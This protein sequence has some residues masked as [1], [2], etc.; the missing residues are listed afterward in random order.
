MTEKEEETNDTTGQDNEDSRSNTEEEEVEQVETNHQKGDEQEKEGESSSNAE[1]NKGILQDAFEKSTFAAKWLFILSFGFGLI[2][3]LWINYTGDRARDRLLDEMKNRK[4]P[5]RS[6]ELRKNLKPEEHGENGARYYRAAFKASEKLCGPTDQLPL[7]GVEGPQLPDLGERLPERWRKP[8]RR[9]RTEHKP[10]YDLLK[11]ARTYDF[12]AYSINRSMDVDPSNEYFELTNAH[13][14]AI[15]LSLLSLYQEL[16]G[17]TGG[18]VNSILHILHITDSFRYNPRR[19]LS[20]IRLTL[21]SIAISRFQELLSRT[22]IPETE[23]NELSRALSR[24]F[25]HLKITTTLKSRLALNANYLK[26]I[27][28][29][30]AYKLHEKEDFYARNGW[31]PNGPVSDV[32]NWI[33]KEDE[34]T[35]R[36]GKTMGRISLFLYRLHATLAPGYYESRLA[37]RM[38]VQ[39][40]ILKSLGKRRSRDLKYLRSLEGTEETIAGRVRETVARLAESWT[41][42]WTKVLVTRLAI[43][44]EQF[45]MERGRWP[46]RRSEIPQRW[47]AD[48]YGGGP[49]KFRTVQNGVVIYSVGPNGNDDGGIQKQIQVPGGDISF[50]LFDPAKRGEAPQLTPSSSGN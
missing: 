9:F 44:V 16:E 10:L 40:K 29:Y 17:N 48:P 3:I 33:Y 21:I 31:I 1:E 41:E 25:R 43:A 27:D 20:M 22:T 36:T 38:K 49:M 11:K 35:E 32:Y 15:G 5:T 12:H 42:T 19:L 24:T 13:N 39:L 47:F 26:H 6:Q 28:L 8:L 23:R 7:A 14:A 18:A 45:R 2:Y 30:T 34:E 46:S 37:D 50:R 4:L